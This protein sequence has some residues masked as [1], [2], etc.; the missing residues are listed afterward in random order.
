MSVIFSYLYICRK[1][2]LYEKFLLAFVP[3][4]FGFFVCTN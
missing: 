3:F 4:G 2:L 1:K